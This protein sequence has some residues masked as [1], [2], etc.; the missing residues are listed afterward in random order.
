[1]DPNPHIET[2]HDELHLSN[3]EKKRHIIHFKHAKDFHECIESIK[4][5]QATA[6]EKSSFQVMNI[7][8]AISCPAHAV[9]ALIPFSNNMS[10]E[11]DIPL[12]LHAQMEPGYEYSESRDVPF[13]V[14]GQLIP[15][16]VKQVKAPL[17]WNKTRG[18]EIKIGIIDT[19]VDATHPDLKTSIS[20]GVNLLFPG[21]LPNDDNGHGTHIAGIIAGASTRKGILGVAPQASIHAVKAFDRLGSAYVSD[22]IAGINWCVE[23][24]MDI[25]NM[26]FGMKTYSKALQNAVEQAYKAGKIIIASCGNEGKKATVDYP[27]RFPQVVSV[28]A[29]TQLN[30]IAPF[31][32]KGKRIDIYA[33]GEK[34][35]SCWLY[36][37]YNELSGTSMATAHVSGV[38]AL[39]LST[40]PT[41]KPLQIKRVLKQYAVSL[42][43]EL[44]AS[45]GQI[46]ARRIINA[47][48]KP[49][50][51]PTKNKVTRRKI[52]KS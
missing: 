23:N 45:A 10:I 39:M 7:I 41:L 29:I 9:P 1:M 24:N 14:N 31:S 40:K 36:S 37:N 43:K 5:W 49:R 27:A 22:I 32:N 47:I 52:N 26:S 18:H 6:H 51:Q 12:H 42:K 4:A 50:V 20:R 11:E 35:Y 21:M 15:W 48:T 2:S 16:G 25:I 44:T 28:G 33:P 38:V 30:R 17:T 34:I 19:G 13:P 46:N 3:N 8:Q